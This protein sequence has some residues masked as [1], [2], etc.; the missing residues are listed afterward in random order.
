MTRVNLGGLTGGASVAVIA[1]G[2]SSTAIGSLVQA[3]GTTATS[4]Y[5]L[6]SASPRIC[7]P[8]SVTLSGGW[9]GSSFG[10][11][12][13]PTIQSNF[14]TISAVEGDKVFVSGL[15]SFS[16]YTPAFYEG[17]RVEFRRITN[18]TMALAGT[19]T[20]SSVAFA[21]RT[22]FPNS[23]SK[24]VGGTQYTHRLDSWNGR[25]V[26]YWFAVQPIAADGQR[27]IL[28][29][30]TPHMYVSGAGIGEVSNT[31]VA[32]PTQAQGGLLAGPGSVTVSALDPIT[33]RI[34]WTPVAGA[35]GYIVH[36]GYTDPATWPAS[37]GEFVLVDQTGG[38]PQA[39]DMIIWRKEFRQL[40]AN[41]ICSRVHSASSSISGLFPKFLNGGQMSL[42]TIDCWE[43]LDWAEGEKPSEEL[44]HH[45][46]RRQVP[47]NTKILDGV[48]WSGGFGQTYYYRKKNG[49]A[50]TIEIWMRA[51]EPTTALFNSGQPG[52][53]SQSFSVGTE[54][55]KY[56]LTS[57]FAPEPAGKTAYRWVISVTGGAEGM[58]LEYAQLRSYLAAEP[59]GT[60]RPHLGASL[61]PGQKARDHSLIKTRTRTYSMRTVTNKP[62]E[63]HNGWTC[64]MHMDFCRQHQLIPWVQLE[65]SLFKE[66]WLEWAEWIATYH[67]DFDKI[68]LELGNEN[69]NT[70]S[71]VFWYFNQMRDSATQSL[72]STGAVYGMTTQMIVDWLKES[73]HWP[74][75]EN[76]LEIVLGGHIG[77][78]FGEEALRNCPDAKYVDM[79]NYNG[80]WDT[81][82]DLSI[83]TG[84]SFRRIL[85]FRG[86]ESKL[87]KREE[88]I[89]AAA[90]EVGKTVGVDLFHDLYEGGPGYQLDG[91]NGVEVSAEQALVQECVQKSRAAALA[92]LDAIC[93][94]WKRGW[95]SNWFVLGSGNRWTSHNEDGTEYLTHAVGRV[96]GASLG[97][98][99]SHDIYPLTVATT[100][101]GEEEIGVHAFESIT[102]PGK[103]L[104]VV[105][106]RAPDRTVLDV[107]DPLYDAADTGIR[108]VAIHTRFDTAAGC[109][110]FRAGLGNMREHNRYPAGTRLNTAGT[111]AD[112]PLCVG[113]DT[114][115]HAIDMPGD[116]SVLRID[117]RFG[118]QP[119]GLRGGNFVMIEFTDMA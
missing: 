79:A 91:L 110:V 104:Y 95:L 75:L 54:W 37:N 2:Q 39:G 61:V 17:A 115:W 24:A 92:Q 74:V 60:L 103:W 8:I 27:G 33:A 38:M 68:L 31:I 99:R 105:L 36:M 88:T 1:D 59:F 67:A 3:T 85:A 34:S 19:G 23:S 69:W 5:A 53:K 57:D 9:S 14:T 10:S 114:D 81:G 45:Y 89:K 52:E 73:P 63:G 46:V 100:Q 78:T 41:M 42:S 98:F 56:H 93:I 90:Q 43:I 44:G 4:V 83:E 35:I 13:A 30:W 16:T 66:D 112:D 21:L 62:G 80:G 50:L 70:L 118:A 97:E 49:D 109:R 15:D 12:F 76:K 82:T 72:Q 113:F 107:A 102:Y 32:T 101:D 111:Y 86:G 28:S 106:N 71:G 65:W 7:T 25:S 11:G 29:A 47:P 20:M 84:D 55:A 48:Y 116:L 64:G 18:G 119:G 58:T 22:S 108:P 77:S 26:N 51:S 94:G 87:I 6:A 40:A 117:E 96:I